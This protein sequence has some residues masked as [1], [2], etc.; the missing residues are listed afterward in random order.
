[1]SFS[2]GVAAPLFWMAVAGLA[3][4]LAYK[5]INTADSMIGH[6][7]RRYLHFGWAT[8]RADDLVNLPASRLAASWLVLG[9]LFR[10]GLSARRAFTTA[11]RDARQHESPNAGWPEAAMAG[12][13][14]VRLMGPRSYDGEQVDGPWMGDG[15]TIANARDIRTAL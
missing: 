14:G 6:K 7:T 13:L 11:W 12:A 4:A 1:E 9:A 5:A 3:G 2:D 8:A 10:P 15:R